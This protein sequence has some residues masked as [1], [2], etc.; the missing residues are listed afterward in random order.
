MKVKDE[1]RCPEVSILGAPVY[2]ADMNFVLE[3]IESTIR[4]AG[5]L[6]VVPVNTD[7]IVK[8]QKDPEFMASLSGASLLLPDSAPIILASW[9]LGR[10]IKGRVPGSD[11]TKLLCQRSAVKGYSLYFLGAAPGVGETAKANVEREFP[12][13]RIVG[14][15]S[16]SREEI[17]DESD[18]LASIV[19][20]GKP[21]IVTVAFGAPF[22]EIWIARNF[23][24]L[25]A[26][27]IMA[28]GSSIDYL[29][30]TQRRAPKWMFKLG[31]EWVYRLLRNPGRL[32]GRYLVDDLIFFPL[33]AQQVW[34]TRLVGRMHRSQ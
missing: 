6:S 15:Y 32:L 22:Q 5:K 34:R 31:L 12:G 21:S 29:A 23:D 19:N 24:R 1:N 7:V 20:E 14:S 10:R 25:T 33:L 11:L 3:R 2:N 26:N 8:A 30:G 4:D 9:L 28:V 27:V 13:A 16:P 18:R 17:I